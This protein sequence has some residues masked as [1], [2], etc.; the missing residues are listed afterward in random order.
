MKIKE[1][2]DKVVRILGPKAFARM[3]R[4]GCE[5]GV[6]GYLPSDVWASGNTFEECFSQLIETMSIEEAEKEVKRVLGSHA[7]A[8]RFRNSCR[9]GVMG[10]HAPDYRAVGSTFEQCFIK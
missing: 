1:A 5:I 8:W 2:G 9:I 3:S 10:L 7:F 6:T 4:A